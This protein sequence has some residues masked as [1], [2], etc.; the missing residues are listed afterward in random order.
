MNRDD[1]IRMANEAGMV[2]KPCAS[3]EYIAIRAGKPEDPNE[4]M[5]MTED[6]QLLI[7]DEG[8]FWQIGTVEVVA[9]AI[10]ARAN[11]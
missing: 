8:Y 11:T 5:R 9:N 6:G 4:R 2:A 1:I 10:S 3:E 7:V